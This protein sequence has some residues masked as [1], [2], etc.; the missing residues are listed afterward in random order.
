M[1]QGLNHPISRQPSILSR[2]TVT[3][4]KYSVKVLQSHKCEDPA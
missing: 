4:R 2:A 1:G 3:P